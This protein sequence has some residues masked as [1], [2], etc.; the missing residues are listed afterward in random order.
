MHPHPDRKR[1]KSEAKSGPDDDESEE[2]SSSDSDNEEKAAKKKRK[3]STKDSDAI[4]NLTRVK[5][6]VRSSNTLGSFCER[7]LLPGP[8]PTALDPAT[9]RTQ[10]KKIWDTLE[11][12][13]V[14]F[15]PPYEPHG[16]KLVYDG[17]PV[18][19][20]AEEEEVRWYRAY[21]RLRGLHAD[22]QLRLRSRRS[23][24]S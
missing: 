13:A 17:K 23:S 20:S 7:D 10:A 16:V 22:C 18:D 4:A 24:P 1:A 14:T 8:C 6:G 5:K 21:A 19:L 15:P 12:N 11:H 2:S 9:G 3:R